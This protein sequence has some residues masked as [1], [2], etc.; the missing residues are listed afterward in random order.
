MAVV[1]CIHSSELGW[2]E[3]QQ[4]QNHQQ[5]HPIT[6]G[7]PSVLC[8]PVVY[9][10]VFPLF[11][12]CRR[13]VAAIVPTS[14]KDGH[15]Y[16]Y[17]GSVLPEAPLLCLCLFFAAAQQHPASSKAALCALCEAASMRP[18]THVP[19]S[20][21]PIHLP[22]FVHTRSPDPPIPIGYASPRFFPTAW[23]YH[24]GPPPK[25]TNLI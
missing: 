16:C 3:Q 17:L 25:A 12:E 2:V 10:A 4:Q 22:P 18:P 1:T 6:S 20:P 13:P 5:H 23:S 19:P 14:G 7:S 11:A 8:T 21:L 24:I 15:G 9:L